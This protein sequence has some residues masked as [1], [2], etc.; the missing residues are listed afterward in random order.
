MP[1][2]DSIIGPLA[3]TLAVSVVAGVGQLFFWLST[4]WPDGVSQQAG[5]SGANRTEDKVTSRHEWALC[6]FP[7][8]FHPVSK[9]HK[10][11]P[12]MTNIVFSMVPLRPPT[13]S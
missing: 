7:S 4:L 5:G 12:L 8:S 6:Q 3:D 1:V 9:G 11:Y 10:K 2:C 13:H